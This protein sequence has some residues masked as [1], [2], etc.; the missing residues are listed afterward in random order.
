MKQLL[1]IYFII[2]IIGSS[3]ASTPLKN[4]TYVSITYYGGDIPQAVFLDP[5][6]KTFHKFKEA[7]L[8]CGTLRPDY[9]DQGW[10]IMTVALG[11]MQDTLSVC[12]TIETPTGKLIRE[13]NEPPHPEF[14][15]VYEI[16]TMLVQTNEK[17]IINAIDSLYKRLLYDYK[18]Q[19]DK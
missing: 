15:T 7:G 2:L 9:K 1:M 5:H 17:S 16:D 11:K 12:L 10:G 13:V 14:Q 18:E 6:N 4:L 19:N 3:F 8:Q